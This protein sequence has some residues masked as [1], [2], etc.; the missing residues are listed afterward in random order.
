MAGL[1]VGFGADW[2]EG[3]ITPELIA[4][5][6]HICWKVRGG[7]RSTRVPAAPRASRLADAASAASSAFN[8]RPVARL[9]PHGGAGETVLVS[10]FQGRFIGRVVRCRHVKD[11]EP[12]NPFHSHICGSACL[13]CTPRGPF[14]A[15]SKGHRRS[16]ARQG[17]GLHQSTLDHL[18]PDHRRQS[19]RLQ[20]RRQDVRQ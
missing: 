6:A 2:L 9:R 4:D 11:L 15:F 20:R 5:K 7:Q 1:V 12:A 19:D 14:R 16:R 18:Q 3:N 17:D 10:G 8:V 13:C